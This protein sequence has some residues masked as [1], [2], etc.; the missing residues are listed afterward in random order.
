MPD[1]VTFQGAAK[2]TVRD[3]AERL[4][5]VRLYQYDVAG[6]A[7][8]GPEMIER[9]AL[10]GVD[11]GKVVVRLDHVDPL[12]GRAV[13]LS[14][15]DDGDGPLAT[16]RIA[17]TARGD[18]A[19]QLAAD[20][21]Y[22][23]A[24][25]GFIKSPPDAYRQVDG[26]RVAIRSKLD[27]RE[28]SLTWHPAHPGA[29]VLAVRKEGDDMSETVQAAPAAETGATPDA[30]QAAIAQ[31]ETR[32]GALLDDR[33]GDLARRSVDVPSAP[34]LERGL[35]GRYVRAALSMLRGEK[36][37]D[38]E[39]R[40]LADIVTADN[41]GVVPK[42]IRDELIGII[43]PA[44]PF[45][46]STRE[47]PAGDSGMTM[48]FPVISQRPKTGV[49]A[50]EKDELE[51]QK[52][53]IT[54]TDFQSTT[55]GGAGDLSMQLIKRSSPSYFELWISLVA[56]QYALNADDE[57]VDALLAAGVQAGTGAFD[58]ESPSFGE[59][60][61]NAM[62]VSRLMMPDRIWLSTAAASAFV[63]AKT[64]SGGAGQPL[65]PGLVNLGGITDRQSS[66][67]GLN[68]RAVHVP[69]LDDEAVDVII[70]P[71][72]GF[73]WAEDGTYTLQAD[74]PTKFGRDVGLA[75]ILWFMPVYPAAFTTYA[76]AAA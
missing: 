28:I 39:I 63:D 40:A 17:Q 47:V 49:Q 18:E 73:A 51:S 31:I 20:G 36:V 45:L 60:F 66:G 50:A 52:T 70:G 75:G 57:A 5:D 14:E 54:S 32:M 76:L 2:L 46:D 30:I 72:K 13:E 65:Y 22:Q 64:A 61:T 9:G 6:E 16:L 34:K 26:R 25:V 58:P 38:L 11:V 55:I 59:A 71:S 74:V 10:A 12:I 67:F 23:G 62:E 8:D 44:R 37:S 3:A 19:L 35:T 1:L 21:L 4:V 15:P 7:P 33:L 53:I 41:L 42:Q 56:E 69:A 43:D 27:L 48:T 29:A 68:L 24:S